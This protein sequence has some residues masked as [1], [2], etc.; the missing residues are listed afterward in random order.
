MIPELRRATFFTRDLGFYQRSLCHKR[1][2]LV[3]MAVE[4]HEAALFIRRL[5]HHG[6]FDTQAKRIGTVIRVSR[7]GLFVWHLHV[8]ESTKRDGAPC[9]NKGGTGLRPITAVFPDNGVRRKK[10]PISSRTPELCG[11]NSAFVKL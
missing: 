1:Y 4:K 8:D 10:F 9:Q 5:L 11:K 7:K 3:C 6:E 2:C